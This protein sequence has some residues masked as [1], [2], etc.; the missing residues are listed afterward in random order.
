MPSGGRDFRLHVRDNPVYSHKLPFIGSQSGASKFWP[1]ITVDV[2]FCVVLSCFVWTGPFCWKLDVT[3]SGHT[4]RWSQFAGAGSWL[5]PTR[6]VAGGARKPWTL[7]LNERCQYTWAGVYAWQRS[8][9]G[10]SRPCAPLFCGNVGGACC[11][12]IDV[13]LNW[14]CEVW[15]RCYNF[16]CD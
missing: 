15:L 13:V 7:P 16:A 2:T 5:R 4:L 1:R 12:A 14:G 9:P 10:W 6:Q 11:A 3:R 8:G